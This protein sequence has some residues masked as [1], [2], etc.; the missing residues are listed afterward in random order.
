MSLTTFLHWK[1]AHKYWELSHRIESIYK[2]EAH[3]DLSRLVRNNKIVIFNIF[4]WPAIAVFMF[5]ISKI[6]TGSKFM[7]SLYYIGLWTQLIIDPLSFY[8]LWRAFRRI[9][10]F[11]ATKNLIINKPMMLLHMVSYT[12]FIFSMM[13]YLFVY[14]SQKYKVIS[15]MTIIICI[16]TLTSEVILVY[17]FIRICLGD[18]S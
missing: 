9:R 6:V 14:A 15:T 4:F 8:I 16:S 11:S 18:S 17:I 12:F 7:I 10:T 3:P 5:P 2:R 1:F 13:L